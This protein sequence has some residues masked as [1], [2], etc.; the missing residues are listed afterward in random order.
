MAYEKEVEI[1]KGWVLKKK[2]MEIKNGIP[3]IEHQWE[4][5]ITNETQKPTEAEIK[6]AKIDK[7][8]VLE[9]KQIDTTKDNLGRDIPIIEYKWK[10]KITGETQND[11]SRNKRNSKGDS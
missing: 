7:A 6:G 3:I 10:N 11:R 4:N 5:T 8:W 1:N 9:G 2:V